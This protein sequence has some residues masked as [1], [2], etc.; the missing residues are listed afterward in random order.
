MYV[1]EG[2]G[3]DKKLGNRTMPQVV[4]PMVTETGENL[5]PGTNQTQNVGGLGRGGRERSNVYTIEL[6]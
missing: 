3:S 4:K 1:E 2:R 6:P 5:C